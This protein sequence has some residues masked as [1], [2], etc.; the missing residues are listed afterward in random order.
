ML[1][2]QEQQQVRMLTKGSFL[3]DQIEKRKR[4]CVALSD[5]ELEC[6][7]V[8]LLHRFSDL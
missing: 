3:P 7:N 2:C 5:E 4:R 1:T 6:E 8:Y